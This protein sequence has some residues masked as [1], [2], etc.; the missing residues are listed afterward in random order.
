MAITYRPLDASKREFRL[1]EIQP[2]GS[3]SDPVYCRIVTARLTEKEKPDYI[4]LSSLYSDD[5]PDT[6]R[7]IVNG[8]SVTIPNHISQALRHVRAVFFPTVSLHFQRKPKRRPHKAPRWLR[9]LFGLESSP[10]ASSA[11]STRGE[12][13]GPGATTL[14]LWIDLLCVN[15]MDDVEKSQQVV[16]MRK[17]YRHAEL[18][19]GWLGVK[20]EHTDAGMEVLGFIDETMPPYWGDP[21][22]REKN[23]EDYAPIHQWAEPLKDVWTAGVHWIGGADFFMRPYLQR[24][25]ILEELSTARYP[26]FLIGDIIVPWKQLLRLTTLMEEFKYHPSKYFPPEMVPSLIEFP[27]ETS[28]KFLEEFA[29]REAREDS[30]IIQKKTYG[31]STSTLSSA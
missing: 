9:E 28:Q 6:D 18:V 15:H 4:A 11:S 30:K 27:L 20:T 25:W 12:G 2:A 3:I 13:Y 1:L 26:V 24:R 22:D 19:V 16:G 5:T 17:I 21:G 14:L 29:R 31:K 23:P 10:S 8:R 7:I